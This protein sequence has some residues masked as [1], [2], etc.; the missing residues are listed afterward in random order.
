MASAL[1]LGDSGLRAGGMGPQHRAAAAP[2][3]PR[4]AGRKGIIGA[5]PPDSSVRPR[6]RGNAKLRP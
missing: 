2:V 5:F 3:R 1:P 6:P 4:H